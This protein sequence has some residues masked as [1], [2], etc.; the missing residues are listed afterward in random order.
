MKKIVSCIA[1]IIVL[2]LF[3]FRSVYELP[4]GS[5]VP[6]PDVKMKDITGKE[7][8]FNDVK[9]Q[10]GLL[11]MFTCNTCPVV[12]RNQQRTKEICQQAL[13]KNIGVILL[14]A[15]EGT[16][17]DGDSFEDMQRYAKDQN[18]T[19]QYAIDK[20]SVMA[21]AFGAMRT[22]ECFLFNKDF[23]LV[24]HGAIDNNPGSAADASKKYL[25]NA[26]NEMLAGKDVTV[27]VT[28]SIGC[29]IKRN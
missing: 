10:G 2:S 19:W 8:S 26:I 5:P 3:A 11:V 7:V 6:K 4:I 9:K 18:Y 29:G 22:P 1:L 12:I 14:N 17:S 28:R 25:S 27:K 16:R 15:N 23:T 24:Y 20:N 21:D 13:D